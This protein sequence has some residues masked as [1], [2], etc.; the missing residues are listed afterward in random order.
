MLKVNGIY[1]AYGTQEVLKNACL[2]IGP[3]IK[4]LIGINGWEVNTS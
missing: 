2:E 1:K 3:E 4:V